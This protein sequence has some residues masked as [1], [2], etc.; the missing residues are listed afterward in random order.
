VATGEDTVEIASV[1]AQHRKNEPGAFFARPA[2][3]D[4]VSAAGFLTLAFVARS[5]ERSGDL[6]D[7]RKA[8]AAAPH[9]GDTP[10]PFSSSVG[11]GSVRLDLELPADFFAD[12]TAMIISQS[13]KLK[14]VFEK[15][16]AKPV[17]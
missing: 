16:S 1:M 7:M 4:L 2:R 17:Q 14:G 6:S 10:L 3:A 15:R 8:L 12:V 5:V 13:S 9:H 11:P